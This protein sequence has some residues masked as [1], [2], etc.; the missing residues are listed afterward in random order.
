M[1][2][3][4]I[5]GGVIG[6]T[7]AYHLVKLGHGVTLIDS[8][9]IGRGASHG[10]AGWIVPAESGPVAAPG[11]IV[12]GLKW[13]LRADSPLYIRPSL[14]RDLVR[15]LFALARRCNR[16]DYR[17]VLRANIELSE[18]TMDLLDGY[19]R[20]GVRFEMHAQGLLM[21]FAHREK[22]IAHQQDLDIPQ[23]L[24]L[25]PHVLTGTQLAAQE[26]ALSS[27]LAGAIWFPHER[28]VRPDTLVAGLAGACASMGVTCVEDAPVGAVH[29]DGNRVVAVD[30]PTATHE[31]EV[32]VVAAGAM[33]GPLAARFGARLPVRPGKGYSVDFTP[34][35]IHLKGIV[36][37]CDDKVAVTPLDGALRLAGTMEF[38]GWDTEVNAVRVAAIRRAPARYFTEWTDSGPTTAPWA[39]ARPMT[40]DGLPIIGRIPTTANAYVATGHGMLGVTLGPATG[41]LL[42]EA[43]DS[44]SPP[45]ALRAFAPE[46]FGTLASAG[47]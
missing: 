24:G 29:R 16:E 7:S 41:W 30:T 10:N 11:M 18:H 21:A 35:P 32:F 4:V 6:L 40:P 1:K 39:G 43:I 26:P 14:D 36:N 38:A 8:G 34:P 33:S 31:A 37:L 20:D 15:F 25:D 17:S 22:L 2:V 13:M 28:H 46:R 9:Q 42:A 5:G 27:A 44:G 19:V 47:R 12:Q 23:R 3:V 45:P